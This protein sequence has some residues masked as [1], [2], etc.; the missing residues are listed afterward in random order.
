[1]IIAYIVTILLL[2]YFKILSDK[3]LVL[4]FTTA[5][6]WL[7]A[8]FIAIKNL[9]RARKDNKKAKEYE[10]KKRIEI[11]AFKEINKAINVL[12]GKLTS[13]STFFLATL[14]N[15]LKN[16]VENPTMFSYDPIKRDLEKG[17]LH[18]GLY[19]GMTTFLLAIEANEIA[20]IDFDYLR[21]YMH[22]S[23]RSS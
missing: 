19:E 21:K 8:L 6:G 15:H 11:D 9:D 22:P 2:F 12:S 17:A 18:V 23:G 20:A 16:H 10:I 13:L 5:F 3:D 1:M 4:T 7:V 14:P